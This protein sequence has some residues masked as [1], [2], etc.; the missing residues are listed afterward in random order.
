L[1]EF[2]RQRVLAESERRL[3]SMH[4]P[5]V[6]SPEALAELRAQIHSVLD[7]AIATTA[8][9]AA[10]PNESDILDK[11]GSSAVLA[12][13]IGASRAAQ[14]IHP[15]ESLRAAD[16]LFEVA[17]PLLTQECVAEAEGSAGAA[18]LALTLHRAI[19]SR[20]IQ[21]ST[22]YV[23]F[24]L[25][26]LWGS[27][28]DERERMARELHDRA[29][30]AVGVGLQNLQLYD[31]YRP[32]E[33]DRAREKFEAA[34][35]A[36]R[37]ALQTIRQLSAELRESVGSQGLE[38]ALLRYLRAN[39][40]REVEVDFS[41]VGDTS[42]LT[43]EVSEEVYLVLREAVRNALVHGQATVVRVDLELT[44]SEL[45]AAVA[46]N[47]RGFDVTD[48]LKLL[49][50]SGSPSPASIGMTSMRE[51]MELLGG[52]LTVSS[53]FGSGTTVE[54]RLP[55]SRGFVDR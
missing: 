45:R 21:A 4:S 32:S 14:G 10:H 11:D 39:V 51:R 36:L 40:P 8:A 24:L 49:D 29:A 33:P 27:H 5:I 13:E 12:V 2:V 55:L 22:P 9:T 26:K 17:L 43:R 54:A 46:D 19:M 31:V 37:E 38:Q 34:E 3:H 7:E 30:H 44:D 50:H 52:T 16:I 48:I 35:A 18:K 25:A 1:P 47:G 15:A 42:S 28:R 6:T 20:V 23:N 53:A 41:V